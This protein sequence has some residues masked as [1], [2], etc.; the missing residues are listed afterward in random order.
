M[1]VVGYD[2]AKHIWV[3][4]KIETWVAGLKQLGRFA[5][6]FSQIAYDSLAMSLHQ[7]WQFFQPLTPVVGPLF[8]PL[9]AVLKEKVL[10]DLLGFRREEISN[11]LCKQITWRL[12]WVGIGITDPIQNAPSKFEMLEHCCVVLNSSLL[13]REALDLKSQANQTREGHEAGQ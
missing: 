10:L 11:S 7:E 4:E 5:R 9:E 6:E 13:N 3:K 12:K 2:R 1:G 8:A